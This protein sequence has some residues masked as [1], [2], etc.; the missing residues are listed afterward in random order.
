MEDRTKDLWYLAV[1]NLCKSQRTSRTTG[2]RFRRKPLVELV[3]LSLSRNSTDVLV[4]SF[5]FPGSIVLVPTDTMD[6][7]KRM[8]RPKLMI[9]IFI[10]PI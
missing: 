4:D 9:G 8:I 7:K 2:F 1:V 3:L 6:L 5:G 10:N